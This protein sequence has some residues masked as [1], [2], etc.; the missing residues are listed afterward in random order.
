MLKLPI[1]KFSDAGS[2]ECKAVNS[3]GTAETT[4]LLDVKGQCFGLRKLLLHEKFLASHVK[5]FC[6]LFI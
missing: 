2:Y 1:L 3:A 4:A 5:L 6:N